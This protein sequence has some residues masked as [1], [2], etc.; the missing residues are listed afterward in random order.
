MQNQSPMPS[1][2]MIAPAPKTPFGP[3][4]PGKAPYQTGNSLSSQHLPVAEKKSHNIIETLLLLV[5]TVV[6]IVFIW[7]FVQ[8]SVDYETATTDV[9][10]QID[11]AVAMAVAENTTKMEEVFFERE[12]NPYKEFLGPSDYGS[13]SFKYPKT[14]SVYVERD[15]SNGGDFKAY[16]NPNEVEPVSSETINALRVTIRDEAFDRVVRAYESSVKNGKLQFEV[17]KVG[18]VSA[19]LYV[20]Q[21]PNRIYGALVVFK[22]RDK[23]VMLQTDAEIHISQFYTILD[24]VTMNQ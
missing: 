21:L 16:L 1:G 2:S 5:A 11:A 17:R 10:G 18:G 4:A 19:N 20:G 15:A 3:A 8:K 9:D 23:T 6:A 13:L 7:L 22:L 14:W 12:K 24:T